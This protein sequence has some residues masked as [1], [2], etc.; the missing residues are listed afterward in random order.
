MTLAF[1]HPVTSELRHRPRL[2][3]GGINT[4]PASQRDT[5]NKARGPHT[6]LSLQTS[7]HQQ[8]PLQSRSPP[9]SL[10]EQKA[11]RT[12]GRP[13]S[14]PPASASL[15]KPGIPSGVSSDIWARGRTRLFDVWSFRV[16]S[17]LF[18]LLAAALS[19]SLVG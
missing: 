3:G 2:G 9:L 1:G 17:S 7:Q 4:T 13:W 14:G 5:P 16:K 11:I 6:L 12:R 8:P 15:R 18:P 10:F 19:V